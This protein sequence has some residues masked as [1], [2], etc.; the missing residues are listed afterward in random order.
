MANKL[1]LVLL[2]LAVIT[3][4]VVAADLTISVNPTNLVYDYGES[5]RAYLNITNR[6]ADTAEVMVN[7]NGVPTWLS[8]FPTVT[9][10]IP[11][12]M[13]AVSL[14]P[15]SKTPPDRYLYQL[16]VYAREEGSWVKEWEGN[17]IIMVTGEMPPSSLPSTGKKLIIITPSQLTPG[18][19]SEISFNLLETAVPATLDL[20]L[21]KDELVIQTVSSEVST[22]QA[23]LMLSIP[24][25]Q[26]AG[27]YQLRAVLV[28][29]G[30]LNTTWV[31]IPELEKVSSDIREDSR[32]LGTRTYVYMINAGNVEKSGQVQ[33]RLPIFKRLVFN[34]EPE[35][36]T[37]KDDKGVLMTWAYTVA[38]GENKLVVTHTIDYTPYALLLVL[39]VLALV[40]ILQKPEPISISKRM[41]QV[42][43]QE[44]STVVKI[45]I[46][47][48]NR[49]DK[50]AEDVVVED[51]VPGIAMPSKFNVIK[52]KAKKIKEGVNLIWNLGRMEPY[53][54]RL[55]GY[56]MVLGFGLIGD[57]KLPEPR[58]KAK[59]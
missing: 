34:S 43:E 33:L 24:S 26:A 53:E 51:L 20:M 39:V 10:I 2:A 25:S 41:E 50:S 31:T 57:L 32:F 58:I 17:W 36:D 8:I 38:P 59:L 22:P 49:S 23:S 55:F 35:P 42:Y 48:V 16:E 6:G 40:L 37:S 14:I 52:P 19:T 3:V 28:G 7:V 4:P 30:I 11:G 18:T 44:G 46:K 56:E 15:S 9:S 47:I 27:N 12:E 13:K 29:K 45:L 5:A 1:L 54:E 21:L